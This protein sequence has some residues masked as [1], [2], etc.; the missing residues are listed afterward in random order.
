MM[1]L[2]RVWWPI[3][4]SFDGLHPECEVSDWRGRPYF[5]DLVWTPV[6]DG[7]C[8]FAFEIKGFGPHVQQTD[9]IR[10]RQEL[11]RETYLHVLGFKVVAIPYDDLAEQPELTISL[12][13]M[14]LSPYLSP[15]YLDGVYSRLERDVLMMAIRSNKPLRPADLV[16]E[17]AINRRT[18]VRALQS[19]TEKGRFRAL[20]LGK[21]ARVTRYEY[22]H[23]VADSWR[24]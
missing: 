16:L 14:L 4:G 15:R 2:G 7:K 3:F 6:G 17:L 5:L 20:Q 22:I 18:A 23:S 13:K 1:F 21:S 12:L 8:K 11:N 10:Y 9:R 24:W 19:L